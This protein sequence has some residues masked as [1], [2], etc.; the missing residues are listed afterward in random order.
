MKHTTRVFSKVLASGLSPPASPSGHSITESHSV[1]LTQHTI[2]ITPC[3]Q[4]TILLGG[5]G[6]RSVDDLRKSKI[7]MDVCVEGLIHT[8]QCIEFLIVVSNTLALLLTN[9]D[10]IILGLEHTQNG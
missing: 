7:I 9:T 10:E 5:V 8:L 3:L 4:S 1:N 6:E 2:I